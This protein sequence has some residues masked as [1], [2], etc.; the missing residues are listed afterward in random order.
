MG[1]EMENRIQNNNDLLK[2]FQAY[3]DVERNLSKH[4]LRAYTSDIEHFLYWL[5]ELNVADVNT[6]TIRLYLSQI[7]VFEYSKTTITRK[8]AALRTFYRFLYRERIIEYNP[9]DG[10]KSPK[11][12]KRLP[13]FLNEDEIETVMNQVK[14]DT[15]TNARNRAILEVLYACGM[16]VGELCGLNFGNLNLEENEITVFGKGAKER[17]VLISQR[18][19]EY[20][21][22]YIN[23]F[24]KEYAK[25]GE[26]INEDTP[27]FINQTGYRLT[28][29]SVDKLFLKLADN[30]QLG[31]KLSPHVFRH[32][33]ATKLLEKGA[34]LR[35]VQELLGHASISNTQIYTHVSTERLKQAYS[36]AH[37][38]AK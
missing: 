2:E 17:I 12:P 5:K 30:L 6:N 25:E 15:P 18:A 4:T 27:V 1:V 23:D 26:F 11:K 29:R 34:D 3:L 21:N 20:L 13:S 24:R 8:I 7:Q 22:L 14:P 9:V 37:P 36:K 33:F 19:K 16:R 32:S 35:V 28:T 31:K 38:R 10:I